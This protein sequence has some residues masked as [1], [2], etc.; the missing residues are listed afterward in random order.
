MTVGKEDWLFFSE[1]LEDITSKNTLTDREAFC[2]ARTLEM[3]SDYVKG[4]G[5]RFIF[6]VAP[7]KATLHSDNL[8]YF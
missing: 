8:P 3:I 5:G 6:A 1:T 7:N 2:A 4:R